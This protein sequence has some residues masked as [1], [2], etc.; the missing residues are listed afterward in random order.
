MFD[1]DD[2][3]DDTVCDSVGALTD[4]SDAEDIHEGI[5]MAAI[6]ETVTF[7][8]ACILR[9]DACTASLIELI[10]A[11]AG[12]RHI[13]PTRFMPDPSLKPIIEDWAGECQ[14]DID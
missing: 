9:D 14:N 1:N 13:P 5:R 3:G 2:D 7:F 8:I 4:T 6:E 12:F 10:G 11:G